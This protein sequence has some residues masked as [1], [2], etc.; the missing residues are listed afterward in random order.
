MINLHRKGDQK[1]KIASIEN[2]LRFMQQ[3]TLS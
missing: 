1:N 3:E 2:A